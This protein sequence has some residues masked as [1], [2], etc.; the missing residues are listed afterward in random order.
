MF[1]GFKKTR[2]SAHQNVHISAKKRR[3]TV[4]ELDSYIP[5][6]RTRKLSF[7]SREEGN[8]PETPK[9]VKFVFPLLKKFDFNSLLI[10]R[11]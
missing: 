5:A 4:F 8:I 7:I 11:F 10:L 2:F 3:K 9:A 6:L 1:I